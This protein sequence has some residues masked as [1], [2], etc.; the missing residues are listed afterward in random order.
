M[1][2]K[3]LCALA[4]AQLGY[5]KKDYEI[6]EMRRISFVHASYPLRNRWR[7]YAAASRLCFKILLESQIYDKEL[8]S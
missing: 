1:K 6:N 3:Y 2:R 5:F 4:Y 7:Y 8:C